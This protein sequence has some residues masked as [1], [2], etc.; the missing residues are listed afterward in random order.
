MIGDQIFTDVAAGNLSGVRTIMVRPQSEKDLW[1]T[2]IF[3]RIENV[4]YGEREF[5]E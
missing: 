4:I 5:E 2:L 1:Y 3:R